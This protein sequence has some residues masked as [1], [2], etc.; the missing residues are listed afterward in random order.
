MY[1]AT[2]GYNNITV[3]ESMSSGMRELTEADSSRII[4]KIF[5]EFDENGNGRFSKF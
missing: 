3:T 4:E 1:T 5:K 2:G